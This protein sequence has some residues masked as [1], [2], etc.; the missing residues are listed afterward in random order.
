MVLHFQSP[1]WVNHLDLNQIEPH[2]FQLFFFNLNRRLQI[3]FC[4]F[5]V[6]IVKDSGF[7]GSQLGFQRVPRCLFYLIPDEDIEGFDHLHSGNVVRQVENIVTTIEQHA[8]HFVKDEAIKRP[9]ATYIS[10]VKCVQQVI[11]LETGQF[12]VDDSRIVGLD[13]LVLL[14]AAVVG[15]VNSERGVQ[16]AQSAVTHRQSGIAN[17]QQATA[18]DD[19]YFLARK[20]VKYGYARND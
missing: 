19:V 6:Q 10:F 8:I 17:G 1:I 9:F 16:F 14:F 4:Y 13:S 12:S 3:I 18:S 11:T 5:S 7:D 15:H 20:D 2:F